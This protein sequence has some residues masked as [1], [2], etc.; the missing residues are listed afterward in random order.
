MNRYVALF[1]GILESVG[2]D[3]IQTYIQSGNAVFSSSAAVASLS[4]A[5]GAAVEKSFGFT[6]QVL[7]LDANRFRDIAASN[8]FPEGEG[9]PKL[10]AKIERCLGVGTTARNWRTVSKLLELIFNQ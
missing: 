5:I 10:A 2:C 8:P 6:P 3:N 9:T 7:L 1:R 4:A